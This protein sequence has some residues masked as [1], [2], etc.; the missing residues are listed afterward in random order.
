[1]SA[2]QGQQ[3]DLGQRVDLRSGGRVTSKPPWELTGDGHPH[4]VKTQYR[5]VYGDRGLERNMPS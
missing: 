1:M 2:E 5:E 4:Q 3:S